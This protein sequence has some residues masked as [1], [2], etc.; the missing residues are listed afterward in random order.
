MLS[1]LESFQA[2]WLVWWQG[3]DAG[4]F[5]SSGGASFF[6]MFVQTMLALGFVCGLA[7]VIFRWLLPRLQVARSTGRM[8]R[9][10]DR[11]S[12]DVRRS[13]YVVEVAGR[14]LLVASSEAGLQLLS[15]LDAE[16]AAEAE[17]EAARLRP[18][19]G[20]GAVTGAF[21]ERLAQLM[22]R[23]GSG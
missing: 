16:T 2:V 9:V 23:K 10:V 18:Q 15:E 1:G 19:F 17:Q 7:Y 3:G 13:L 11:T 4:S 22:N 5:A 12:L 14:W 21:A 6:M 20:A 8:V